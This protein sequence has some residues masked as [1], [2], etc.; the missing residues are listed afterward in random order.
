MKNLLLPILIFRFFTLK[1]ILLMYNLFSN[2]TISDYFF[3]VT[4]VCSLNKKFL[5][6]SIIDFE[7]YFIIF[8]DSLKGFFLNSL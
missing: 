2:Y 8:V 6:S 3:C 1:I 7:L 5:F 4:L